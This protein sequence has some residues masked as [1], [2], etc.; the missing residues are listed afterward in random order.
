[1]KFRFSMRVCCSRRPPLWPSRAGG[2]CVPLRVADQFVR[3][4]AAG[5]YQRADKLFANQEHAFVAEFMA[6]YRNK[7]KALA[8]RQSFAQW[9]AGQCEI[10]LDLIDHRG[11]GAN[12]HFV[13]P[14][15][16]SG[17]ARAAVHRQRRRLHG[18]LRPR[19]LESSRR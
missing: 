15:S 17:L 5:D 8:I 9:L 13:I 6:D 1:M 7:A 3:A 18:L 16:G 19:S 4:V 14:V 11:L 12:M 2:G 10:S